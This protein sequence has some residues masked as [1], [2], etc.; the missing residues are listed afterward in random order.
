[1]IPVL[2]YFLYLLGKLP[3]LSLDK[4]TH[5][6]GSFLF[7]KCVWDIFS[8]PLLDCFPS[9]RSFLSFISQVMMTCDWEIM[10]QI[11]NTSYCVKKKNW[12]LLYSCI[13]LAT[14]LSGIGTFLFHVLELTLRTRVASKS[15]RSLY[16]CLPGAG[17]ND[18][19]HHHPTPHLQS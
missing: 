14:L 13:T 1:M 2:I 5:T 10:S 18:V 8:I 15:Q 11:S 4:E 7:C 3:N 16:L 6:Y 17:I 12:H 9:T 19:G